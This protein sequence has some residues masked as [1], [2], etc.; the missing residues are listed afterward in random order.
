MVINTKIYI[1]IKYPKKEE[2]FLIYFRK[3]IEYISKN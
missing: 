3:I 2:K 1:K